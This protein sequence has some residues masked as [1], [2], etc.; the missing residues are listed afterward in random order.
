MNILSFFFLLVCL[1]KFPSYMAS[2]SINWVAPLFHKLRLF[3]TSFSSDPD[4]IYLSSLTFIHLF[5]LHRHLFLPLYLKWSPLPSGL[6]LSTTNFPT[7]DC[8]RKEFVWPLSLCFCLT[9]TWVHTQV[10]L[11]ILTRLAG[12]G[13]LGIHCVSSPRELGISHHHRCNGKPVP[14]FSVV[15]PLGLTFLLSY[16]R[17][18]D[19]S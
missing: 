19:H 7:I 8:F 2:L 3:L 10:K 18:V 9:C 1:L 15:L 17:Q 16:A 13:A 6:I 11:A 4:D 14:A 5:L 12:Q